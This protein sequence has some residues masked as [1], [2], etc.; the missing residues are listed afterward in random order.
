MRPGGLDV[1]LERTLHG[2]IG[3]EIR[4]ELE[5]GIGAIRVEQR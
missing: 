2:E 4:L 5:A 3:R 1:D